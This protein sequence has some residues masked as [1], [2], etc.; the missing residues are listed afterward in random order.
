VASSR[1]TVSGRVQGV[2]YRAWT[3]RVARSLGLNGWVRNL[4]NG[5]VEILAIGPREAITE[6]VTRCWRGPPAATV[7]DIKVEECE[8]EPIEGFRQRRND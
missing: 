7:A 8:A 3:E 2:F 5:D 6:L 1:I 4:S